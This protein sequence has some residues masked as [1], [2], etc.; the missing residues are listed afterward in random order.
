MTLGK[1]KIELVPS[2]RYRLMV[3]SVL[4]ARRLLSKESRMATV[5]ECVKKMLYICVS[6]RIF[7]CKQ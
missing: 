1:E 4:C 6:L 2:K 3:V 5:I 7:L